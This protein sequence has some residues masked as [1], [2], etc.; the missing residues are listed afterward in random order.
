MTEPPPTHAAASTRA[1]REFGLVVGGVLL[2]FGGWWIFRR[3]FG[4]LGPGFAG[5]GALL[6]LVALAAPRWLAGPRRAWM[7]AGEAIGAV[8][9][10]LVLALVFFGVVTPIGLAKRLFGWD[11]LE[12]RAARQTS[13]W[14]PYAARQRDPKHFEKMF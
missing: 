14:R 9:A 3:R 6:L 10:Q 8:V 13:Y 4:A 11:P 2:A 12:R 1:A 7:A 5:M